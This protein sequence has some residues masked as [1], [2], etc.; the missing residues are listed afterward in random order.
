MH[1]LHLYL[2]LFAPTL[3]RLPQD[4]LT[5][6]RWAIDN[7]NVRILIQTGEGKYFTTG[8]SCSGAQ[9]GQSSSS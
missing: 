6:T 7:P 2:H 8:T 5:A 1:C 4:M 9:V 3:I